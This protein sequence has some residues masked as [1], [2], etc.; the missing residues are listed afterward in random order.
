MTKIPKYFSPNDYIKLNGDLKYVNNFDPI[1]HF[2]SFGHNENRKYNLL[3]N[4]N[5]P[6]LLHFL[7]IKK[8]DFD[9][10][11]D[12]IVAYKIN[13][14]KISSQIQTFDP[15][16]YTIHSSDIMPI[17]ED[18][19]FDQD[20]KYIKNGIYSDRELAKNI[21]NFTLSK[22]LF[23]TLNKISDPYYIKPN[24]PYKIDLLKDIF[25]TENKFEFIYRYFKFHTKYI[26]DLGFTIS[27]SIFNQ[28]TAVIVETRNHILLK[29]IVYNIMFNLGSEWNLHIFCGFDN[30]I[31]VKNT[32]PNVK[33][34]L[35]PFHNL[36]VDLYDFIFLN[37]FF[38]NS[39]ETE[40]ILI[41]QTDTYLVSNPDELFINHNVYIGAPHRNE[42]CGTNYLTPSK[43]GLNGGLSFRKKSA[44]IHSIN[45]IKVSDI[46]KYRISNGL[47][48][49]VRTPIHVF[50][51]NYEFLNKHFNINQNSIFIEFQ[52]K[53]LIN[54]YNPSK[55]DSTIESYKNFIYTVF[56]TDLIFEDVF[57][58]HATEMLNY[59]LVG[60]FL[61]KKLF[62]Q[63]DIYGHLID[64]KGVH[65]WDKP[66][67]ALPYHK[68]I[69]KKYTLKLLNKKTL[70]TEAAGSIDDIDHHINKVN[71]LIVCHNMK[72]GTE[73]YVKDVIN[74]NK[75]YITNNFPNKNIS[76]DFIRIKESNNQ[77][78]NITFNDVPIKLVQASTNFLID[79]EY[80]IIHIHYLNEPAFILYRFI[81]E[82]VNNAYPTK[83]I[84]TI[85]DY[86][87]IINDKINEY[88][89]TIYNTN[90]SFLDEIKTKP[91]NINRMQNYKNMF[92]KADLIL[93][94]STVCKI[95]YNYVFDLSHNIIKVH[96]HPEITYF[97]PICS[98]YNELNLSTL[99]IAVIG[100]IAVSKGSH[101][102]QDMSSY[103]NKMKI[104]WKIF[105]IGSGFNRNV[106]K[107]FD[108]VS[109]GSYSSEE[110]LRELLIEN[111]I[112]LIWFPAFRHESF[113][114]TLTLAI[115]TNLPII[116]YDSGTFRERLSNYQSP[117]KIHTCDYICEFLY[118]DI[119]ELW[120]QLKNNTYSKI[121]YDNEN[122]LTYD[123]IS[124]E[125]IYAT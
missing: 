11:N 37:T 78:T 18:I 54:D 55:F 24:D 14:D 91:I 96:P 7:D 40:D 56:N 81:M 97:E 29:D 112:N 90:Q 89:L 26:S 75:T 87:F 93:T 36:S 2:L 85:H 109:I 27:N 4:T 65:G 3:A 53:P 57:F 76:I 70:T 107:S 69:I 23:E 34:T 101:M 50:D 25:L 5:Y 61:A 100:S 72:G 17:I 62:I 125:Q 94:G 120:D 104:P 58:S 73:K 39:I 92:Y 98:S 44:M 8:Y 74:I 99:N 103:I 30:F 15:N 114:Y 124:Y 6:Y 123:K 66:Y 20:M 111:K 22:L 86:H 118:K 32:F 116:A 83:L 49:I 19:I 1:T 31:Y 80:D 48:T 35:L 71:I 82:L 46:D 9:Y 108:I 122:L 121:D 102:I 79:N 115:Q 68:N 117:F 59:P 119:F 13:N 38:W 41:F 88:H 106:K 42:H 10:F 113:C 105:H 28:K 63:E 64:I 33:I 84:I 43:F 67:F 77:T 51:I 47:K 110:H 12:L 21:N 95:V 52:Q 16:L 60:H 45:N